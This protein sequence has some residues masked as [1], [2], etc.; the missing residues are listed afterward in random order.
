[1]SGLRPGPVFSL[2]IIYLGI[3]VNKNSN[4]VRPKWC[5]KLSMS[6]TFPS[7]ADSLVLRVIP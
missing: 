6:S 3:L 4:L 7:H 2:Q 1:M 5:P